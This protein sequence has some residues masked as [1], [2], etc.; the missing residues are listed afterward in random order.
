MEFLKVALVIAAALGSTL[1]A[2]QVTDT[3]FGPPVAQLTQAQQQ[4]QPAPSEPGAESADAPSPVEEMTREEMEAE[5]KKAQ[6]ELGGGGREDEMR[7]FRP[8]KPLPADLPIALP[9]NI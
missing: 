3:L 9:S 1:A 8:S 7:E 4:E 2:R 5:L 6:Q